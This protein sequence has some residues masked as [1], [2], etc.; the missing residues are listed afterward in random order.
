MIDS[1]WITRIE[2]SQPEFGAEK[3]IRYQKQYGLPEYDAKI[4]TNS[5]YMADL[6]E[7]ATKLCDNPKQVSNWLMVET[8][9]LMKEWEMEPKDIRF[10]PENLAKL[11]GLTEQGVINSTVAKQVFEKMFRDN[12][13]P[14]EYVDGKGLAMVQDAGVLEEQIEQVVKD[15]PK[16]VTDYQKGKKKALDYLVGQTMKS[17]QGKADPA[18][19]RKILE[20]LLR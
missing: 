18:I 20:G 16:S 3:I 6:F 4:L 8:M 15:N 7:E 2:G 14:V 9:R 1:A 10:T 19:I 17:M 13:D 12:V 5:K 11:V